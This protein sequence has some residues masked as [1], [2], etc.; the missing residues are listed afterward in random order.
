M[1]KKIKKVNF[2]NILLTHDG[3]D[4]AS[5]VIPYA[6]SLASAYGSRLLLLQIVNSVEQARVSMTPVGV[7]LYP[8][9]ADGTADI[10][11]EHKRQARNNLRKINE[12]IL[13]MQELNM[14]AIVKEGIPEE[15][16]VDI[17]KIEHCDLIVMSTRGRSGLGRALLGSVTDYVVRHASCPVLVI[18]PTKGGE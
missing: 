2:K 16:I 13:S 18:H 3:S 7:G 12:E 15:A 5:V 8:V 11:K 9:I 4:L 6:V 1:E 10:L 14:K 17:A